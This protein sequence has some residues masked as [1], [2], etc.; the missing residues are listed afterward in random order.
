[1]TNFWTTSDIKRFPILQH[2]DEWYIAYRTRVP[3]PKSIAWAVV[4]PHEKQAVLNHRQSLQ[5]LA[6]RGGL[7]PM[8]LYLVMHD[9]DLREYRHH[10]TSEALAWLHTLDS[11]LWRIPGEER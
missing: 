7:S 9:L 2:D 11:V 5:G 6:N 3:Y 4:A 1:M 10:T 8:E